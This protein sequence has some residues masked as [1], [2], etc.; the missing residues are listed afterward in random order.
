M[1]TISHGDQ[2]LYTH[3][4]THTPRAN[5]YDMLTFD[6]HIVWTW[7]LIVIIFTSI[8]FVYWFWFTWLLM[9]VVA[10]VAMVYA[11]VLCFHIGTHYVLSNA[12]EVKIII[13]VI[14][15]VFA[16][17]HKFLFI[18]QSNHQPNLATNKKKQK[19][20][21]QQHKS[22]RKTMLYHLTIYFRLSRKKNEFL[23]NCQI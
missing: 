4:L 5:D 6:V 2:Y 23:G 18:V 21:Q 9:A 11:R 13:K 20:K 7:L 19:Q 8:K 15:F 10:V 12:N 22:K 16:A 14:W 17:Q 3:T 1:K